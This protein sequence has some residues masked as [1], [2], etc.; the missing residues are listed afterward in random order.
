M[1]IV[2]LNMAMKMVLGAESDSGLN[3]EKGIVVLGMAVLGIARFD[4]GV[5][6]IV[7]RFDRGYIKGIEVFASFGI[8]V[9][10]E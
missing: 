1:H 8:V 3:I 10:A 9:G 5:L 7:A 4:K 6:D 2:D